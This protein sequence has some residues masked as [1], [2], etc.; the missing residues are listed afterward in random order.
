MFRGDKYILNEENF[1]M[2]T[3]PTWTSERLFDEE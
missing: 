3:S 2:N 1:N